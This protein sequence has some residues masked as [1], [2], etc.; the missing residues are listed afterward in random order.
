MLHRFAPTRSASSRPPCPIAARAGAGSD[1]RDPG[2]AL[3]PARNASAYARRSPSA[4][5]GNENRRS[6][7]D[8]CARSARDSRPTHLPQED[9]MAS[10]ARFASVGGLL[11]AVALRAS[12]RPRRSVSGPAPCPASCGPRSRGE[13]TGVTKGRLALM[14]AAAGYIVSPLDLIPEAVFPVL[15]V[16]DDALVLSWLASRFVEE[17]ETLPRVGARPGRRLPY[18]GGSGSAAGIGARVGYAGRAQDPARRAP[19][20]RPSA[21]TSSPD[22]PASTTRRRRGRTVAPPTRPSPR[23][24]T[25]DRGAVVRPQVSDRSFRRTPPCRERV[26]H[27]SRHHA[28]RPRRRPRRPALPARLPPEEL[29]RRGLPPRTGRLGLV[30]RTD[31]PPPEHVDTVA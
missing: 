12:G 10:I 20:P 13:Y 27:D 24:S 15:G 19:A 30:A 18:A 16:A 2:P 7:V 29:R 9:P 31:L 3:R 1:R 23:S 4:T 21:G 22:P 6:S 11:K 28:P 25:G 17:T 5:V 14:L 26:V 8:R